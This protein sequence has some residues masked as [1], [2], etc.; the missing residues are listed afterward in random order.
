MRLT[1]IF[2]DGLDDLGSFASA[3]NNW[4]ALI[5]SAGVSLSTAIALYVF[6]PWVYVLGAVMAASGAAVWVVALLWIA[7]P[8]VRRRAMGFYFITLMSSLAGVV[9]ALQPQDSPA[10]QGAMLA[11]AATALVSAFLAH[12]F[13]R[14]LSLKA[15]SLSVYKFK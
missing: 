3:I 14:E 11:A 15:R 9:L 8:T 1:Q 10:Q 2:F 7:L 6:A 13:T 5:L 12:E 4:P